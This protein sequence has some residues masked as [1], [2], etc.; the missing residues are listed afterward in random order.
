MHLLHRDLHFLKEGLLVVQVLPL[1]HLNL[2]GP[3]GHLGH[4]LDDAL[5]VDPRRNARHGRRSHD[6]NL[7]L[8][9][10][11][12]RQRGSILVRHFSIFYTSCAARYPFKVIGG[13]GEKLRAVAGAARLC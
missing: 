1:V 3:G 12:G 4:L 5:P 6:S 11:F 10:K 13:G 9:V 8:N 7:L 2:R